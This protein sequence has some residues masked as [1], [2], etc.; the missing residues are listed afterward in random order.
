MGT[1]V[2][3][4]R[5]GDSV[6]EKTVNV[7]DVKSK[8]PVPTVADLKPKTILEKAAEAVEEAVKPKTR[9]GRPKKKADAD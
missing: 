7:P 1:K 4:V 5:I 2:V 3:K 6:F 9:R 8:P